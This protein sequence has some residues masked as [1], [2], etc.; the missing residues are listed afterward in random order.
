MDLQKGLLERISWVWSALKSCS[1]NILSALYGFILKCVIDS[2]HALVFI[3]DQTRLWGL[4]G[5]AGCAHPSH[6]YPLTL[7]GAVTADQTCEKVK[8][9]L[10]MRMPSVSSP[11]ARGS[12]P[13]P[14]SMTAPAASVGRPDH[15]S[16]HSGTGD[17]SEGVPCLPAPAPLAGLTL[18]SAHHA[19]YLST[20]Q[21][22]LPQPADGGSPALPTPSTCMARTNPNSPRPSRAPAS[23]S[24]QATQEG[25]RHGSRESEPVDHKG[26]T[27]CTSPHTTG[28]STTG[29]NPSSPTRHPAHSR[30]ML[31]EPITAL[32]T[33]ATLS[34]CSPASSHR[35]PA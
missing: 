33:N 12:S 27:D 21:W 13:S 18:G 17:P 11:C 4:V 5:S 8:E 15:L 25:A 28:D 9:S 24:Q 23:E 35:G 6:W 30:A 3:N 20:A 1:L 7:V 16:H 31:L 19:P 32:R 10:L 14:A 26:E 2:F 34:D 29:R 22:A